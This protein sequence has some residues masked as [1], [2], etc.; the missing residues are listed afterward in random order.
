MF[1][2]LKSAPKKSRLPEEKIASTYKLYRIRMFLMIFIGYTGYYL[3]RKNFA[4]ASPFL[5]THFDF[6]KTQIGLISS[7]L[8]IAYGLSK[9]ILGGLSDKSNVKYF[10]GI[11]L[12]A[13]SIVSILMGFASSVWLF[14]ILMVCNGFFQGMGAPPCSIVIGKWFSQRERGLKMG[15]WNT[16]H[17]IGG[18]LI[19]PIATLSLFIFGEQHFQSIFFVPA[20]ICI[21][22]A[23]FVF[24]IGADTPASVGLPPIEEFNDDYP[25]VK[26]EVNPTNLSSKE[27]M[28]KYVLKNKYVWYLALANIFVYLIRQGIVNWIPIYLK[29]EKGFTIANANSAMFLFEYAAIPASILLGWLSDVLFKGKRAPLSIICMIGVIIATLA[30]WKTTNYLVTMIAVAFIGC[31]IYGPQLLIGMNLIDVVPSFAV[32]SATGFSG[33]CGYLCGELMADLVLG[34]IADK[35]GWNGA[36]IFIMIGAVMALILLSLTLKIKK[37]DNKDLALDA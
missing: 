19:A 10:I 1:N 34:F 29:Q 27:I 33:L 24:F 5:M 8:A 16:S 28:I 15:V 3:V 11:G 6:S 35:F 26:E 13:S 37:N 31:F 22:I 12:L 25:E 20:A 21:V 7:G 36:F 18:G 17:N 9:F 14:L 4:V 32:G 23:F 30:Y 2:F